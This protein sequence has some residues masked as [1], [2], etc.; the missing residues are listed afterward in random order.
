M[1]AGLDQVVEKKLNF[2][3]IFDEDIENEDLKAHCVANGIA[4]HLA[5]FRL[6]KLLQSLSA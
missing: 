6:R 1:I 4:V 2:A 5:V 3:Q